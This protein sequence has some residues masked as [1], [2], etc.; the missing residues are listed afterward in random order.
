MKIYKLKYSDEPEYDFL[1]CSVKIDSPW[2]YLCWS[3]GARFSEEMPTPIEYY[4]D[5]DSQIEDYPLTNADQFLVSKKMFNLISTFGAKFD[6]YKSIV[7]SP[8]GSIRNDFYTLNFIE[9][10]EALDRKLSVYE[11]DPDFPETK[12]YRIKRLV[13]K[14]KA[15][16]KDVHIFRLGENET[17][18]L[19]SESLKEQFEDGNLTGI[20]FENIELV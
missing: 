18:I 19:I 12:V 5:K 8:N 6:T 10:F 4:S 15:I 3:L 16:P 20:A 9:S 1:V 17:E 11:N 14:K 13:L 7:C 2:F